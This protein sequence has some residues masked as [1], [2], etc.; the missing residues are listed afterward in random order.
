MAKPHSEN[1]VTC[2]KTAATSSSAITPTW[3][4]SICQVAANSATPGRQ[5]R[6]EQ[7]RASQLEFPDL[8]EAAPTTHDLLL[9]IGSDAWC[10]NQTLRPSFKRWLSSFLIHDRI[11]DAIRGFRQQIESAERLCYGRPGV[12]VVFQIK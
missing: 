12:G 2:A 9:E 7:D 3:D 11:E 1:N 4:A 8:P 6:Y 10:G 5:R